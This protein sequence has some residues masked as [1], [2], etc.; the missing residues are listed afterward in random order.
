MMTTWRMKVLAGAAR[1]AIRSRKEKKK[2]KVRLQDTIVVDDIDDVV[3]EGTMAP[4]TR[5]RA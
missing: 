2:E 5:R 3:A 4:A 1:A